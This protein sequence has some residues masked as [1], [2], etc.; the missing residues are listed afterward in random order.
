MH[1]DHARALKKAVLGGL[2]ATY[3]SLLS[4]FDLIVWDRKRASCMFDFDYRIECYTLQEK[5]VHGY[6]VLPVLHRGQPVARLDAKA[7]R[8]QGVFEVKAFCLEAGEV[9]DEP[10]ARELAA[11]IQRC[12][13]WHGTPSVRIVDTS[14]RK[15]AVSLRRALRAHLKEP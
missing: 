8:T 9:L 1:G 11:A 12:V 6:Y 5:R 14:S 7:H 4:P 10:M 13:A 2:Q 3:T 15:A